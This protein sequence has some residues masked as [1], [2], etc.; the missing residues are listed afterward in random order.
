MPARY[1]PSFIN[2]YCLRPPTKATKNS[3]P[4]ISGK[5]SLIRL[6]KPIN[7][8][9]T[10]NIIGL[11]KPQFLNLSCILPFFLLF[12]FL[13]AVIVSA[14]PAPCPSEEII[15]GELEQRINSLSRVE[16][17]LKDLMAGKPK[18]NTP[19]SAL[20]SIDLNDGE[21]V[22]RRINELKNLKSSSNHDG[23]GLG[24]DYLPE[25]V[26]GNKRA[27]SMVT[28]LSNLY[29]RTDSLRLEFLSLPKGS[30][31]KLI[32]ASVDAVSGKKKINDLEK[33][34][35]DAIRQK[36]EADINLQIAEKKALSENNSILRDIATQ[37]AVL[38]KAR[39][40][41][42]N[43]QANYTSEM[44]ALRKLYLE[45]GEKLAEID[46]NLNSEQTTD[47]M[48]SIYSTSMDIWRELVD[49]LFAD[50]GATYYTSKLSSFPELPPY[51]FE[52]LKNPSAGL[53]GEKY[54]A[55]YNEAKHIKAEI[56]VK[57]R[58]TLEE[59]MELHYRLMLRANRIRAK[60]FNILREGNYITIEKILT[61]NH[62]KDF[63][64]E[65]KLVP[66]RWVALFYIKAFDVRHNIMSGINGW[67]KIAEDSI[68]LMFFIGI[69]F[70]FWSVIRKITKIITDTKEKLIERRSENDIIDFLAGF[71][72]FSI[73]Y[74]PWI[75]TLVAV[76][77]SS[78]I[79]SKTVFAELDILLPYI[80]FYCY[81]KIF[82]LF[83]TGA[84]SH[85]ILK[86]KL[87]NR[88]SVA[89]KIR[90]T[91]R[92][93]GLVIFTS[94]S[95]LYA[96]DIVVGEG[97]SYWLTIRVILFFSV[98]V[99]IWIISSW[100]NELAEAIRTSHKSRALMLMASGLEGRF[101]LFWTGPAFIFCVV[102]FVLYWV[103][104]WSEKSEIYNVLSAKIL[105]KKLET[106]SKE[107]IKYGKDLPD[108]YTRHFIL[109]V[110][111]DT[112]Y[113]VS[114]K[115]DLLKYLVRSIEKWKNESSESHSTVVYGD[116]GS[117]KSCL[118]WRLINSVEGIKIISV[119]IPPKLNSRNSV[120]EFFK[121][122]ISNEVDDKNVEIDNKTL[123]V[124]DEAHNL[125]LGEIGGFDGFNAFLE[126]VNSEKN[127]HIYWC[128]T[129]NRLAWTFLY[130]AFGKRPY[131]NE[132]KRM[133]SWSDKDIMAMIEERQAKT[134]F[135]L[136]YEKIASVIGDKGSFE[137]IDNAKT[138]FFK[139]IWQQSNGNPRVAIHLWLSSLKYKPPY[140]LEVGIPLRHDTSAIQKLPEDTLFVFA[141]ILKHENLT[142]EEAIRS[143]NLTY[144][145]VSH[146]LRIGVQSKI[147]EK[148]DDERYRI[149]LLFQNTLINHLA[150]RNF[151]YEQ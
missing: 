94:M 11:K 111:P 46:I 108:E 7:Y 8:L 9:I 120:K 55:A 27:E 16:E 118:L 75:C 54:I 150:G 90:E 65:I 147:L 89:G 112:E 38:E 19:I 137:S 30:R 81:Y 41:I 136:S 36:N 123:L 63:F 64:R 128:M 85:A 132:A 3:F 92:L 4:I 82:S 115:E 148:S 31:Q 107:I 139:L 34:K 43:L 145:V 6:I 86:S 119:T 48:K 71:I 51:P 84:F 141:E 32:Q 74:I 100:K 110:P 114:P 10:Q 124:L 79:I 98:L 131:I 14:E 113:L 59:N 35:N 13:S 125:F 142:M 87:S 70:F 130:S 50:S 60:I 99:I 109:K 135:M 126:I 23:Y 66:Y 37:R 121:K 116:K 88:A 1:T 91:V 20:F 18:S 95:I 73:P 56:I 29:M 122:Y 40:D 67:L 22:S 21:A 28:E 61:E 12:N 47:T 151:I 15:H 101:S 146:A 62:I 102:L 93:S 25:C 149:S 138:D 76:A 103:R 143:S 57:G 5:R 53:D 78:S 140:T 52:I 129:F 24:S 83:F 69:P 133:P 80:S 117:G 127:R 96:T 68:F 26:K 134:E 42:A 97:I 49:N 144:G 77:A 2:L 106:F 17:G 104:I 33:E 72:N 58:Q 45:K 39:S 105:R 44:E